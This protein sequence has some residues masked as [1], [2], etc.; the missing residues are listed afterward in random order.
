[1][2]TKK[3]LFLELANPDKDGFSR[4]VL[5][6]EFTGRYARLQMGNGGDWCR[7]DGS[8]GREFNLRR[9]KKGNKIISVKLE[10]K[11]KLSINKT[12]RSDIKKEIQSKKCAILYTSK[13]Q[14]DH[15]DGHNDD[16][17]V[18]ELSTQKLEDF[19]PLSQSANVAKRQHCKICRK[20]KKRFDA[21]VLGYSVESIKG[22]GVYSGTCVGCYWYDPKEF[23][24]LVSKSF[25]K[26]V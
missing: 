20:T 6:E 26:K 18:L 15:K 5:V 14:V 1:M 8:L 23:N 7:S 11:K 19:Q 3:A 9:N 16:P 25:K 17:S 13:V 10:G 24:K 4:K 2:T 21:R 12:I 22:N